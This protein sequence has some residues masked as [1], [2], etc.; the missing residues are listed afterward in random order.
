M[1][2]KTA[3]IAEKAPAAL[4]PYSAA[5]SVGPFVYAS[6]QTPIDPATGELV[7]GCA[8]CQ[9]TQVLKNVSAVLEAAGLT[10]DDVVK[11]TVFLIDMADFAKMNDA[12]TKFFVEPYPARSTVAVAGLP[13]AARVEIEVVAVRP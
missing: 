12:Y 7:E 10:L 9:T 6:G 1:P 2:E 11:T 13:K 4:G 8:G 5:I 3:I